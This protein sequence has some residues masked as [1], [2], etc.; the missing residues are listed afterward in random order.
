M[1]DSYVP[2]ETQEVVDLGYVPHHY[3]GGSGPVARAVFKTVVG[4]DEPPRWVRLPCTPATLF[5]PYI[6]GFMKTP[7]D[8]R[9]VNRHAEPPTYRSI[10]GIDSLH[11]L[12][13]KLSESPV[14]LRSRVSNTNRCRCQRQ[15]IR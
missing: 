8:C 13:D 3:G 11:M 15:F 6:C 2:G 5:S 7:A 1:I 9:A 4:G 10:S 14:Q 12:S